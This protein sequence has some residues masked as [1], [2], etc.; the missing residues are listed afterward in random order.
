[1]QFQTWLEAL[2]LRVRKNPQRSSAAR[3]KASRQRP[4][5]VLEERTLLS[6]SSLMI[7]GELSIL[8]DDADSIV[9]RTNPVDGVS[10]QVIENGFQS[11]TLGNVMVANVTSINISGGSG[12]NTID[13]SGVTAAEFTGLTSVSV[14]GGDGDDTI[15]GTVDFNDTILAGDGNDTVTVGA[16][17]TSVDGGDGNDTITAG[18]GDD[19]IEGG[20]GH[21]LIM[22]GPG[23]DSVRAGD[24]NDT[25]SGED[26]DDTIDA[27]DGDDL[28]NGNAGMDLITGGF[29]DDMLMGDSDDDTIFGG[30]GADIIGGGDG[31]DSLVGNSQNDTIS[32]EAGDDSISAGSGNDLATGGDGDDFINGQAG[33]DT[34]DGENGNDRAL[35]GG[36]DDQI[37]GGEGDDTL[38]G[39]SGSDTLLGDNGIDYLN[40]GDGSDRLE[41]DSIRV[42][43]NSNQPVSRLFALAIDGNNQF[44]ELDPQSGAEL[45]RFNAP[46][47]FSGQQDGLAFDGTSLFYL[48]GSGTD[49]LYQI[50]PATQTVRHAAPITVGSGEYD[51]LAVIGG[52]VYIMDLNAIDIHVFD[53]VTSSIVNTLNINMVNPT[54]SVLVGGLAGAANPDRLIATETGGNRVVEIDPLTGLITNSFTPGTVGAGQ[55]YGAAVVN[56]E[57]YLG[58]GQQNSYDVFSRQGIFLRSVTLPYNVS[59]LGGDDVGTTPIIPGQTPQNRFNID[60]RFTGQFTPS[61]QA[62]FNAAAA[63][64]EEII[65][66]DVPDVFVPGIGQVDDIVIEAR[67]TAIDGPNGVLGQTAIIAQ[68]VVSNLPSAAFIAFDTFDIAALESSGQLSD[69]VLHEIGHALGFGTIWT[70]LGL[71]SGATGPDPQFL[72]PLSIQEYNLRFGTNAMGVPVE[73]MGGTG[74]ADSHWRESALTTELMTGFLDPGVANPITRL[75]VAQFADLG[76]QVDFAAADSVNLTTSVSSSNLVGERQ[77]INGILTGQFTSLGAAGASQGDQGTYI[78]NT[79]GATTIVQGKTQVLDYTPMMV[80]PGLDPTKAE[81]LSGANLTSA[82]SVTS[83]VKTQSGTASL[84]VP[85]MEPNDGLTSALNID[86]LGFSLDFDSNINDTL[87]INTSTVLPHL[88]IQGTGDGSFDFYSFTI[89]N[90]GD[91]AIF[92]IDFGTSVSNTGV[93]NGDPFDSQLFLFDA[94]GNSLAS[95][96]AGDDGSLDPGSFSS[97]DSFIEFTF[98]TPGTYVIGVSRSGSIAIPGG[99]SGPGVPTGS[100]YTLQVSIQNHLTSGTMTPTTTP[101]RTFGDTLIGGGGNGAGQGD[102]FFGSPGDDLIIGSNENDTIFAGDGMDSIYAGSGDDEINGEGGNDLIRGNGGTDT[103][104]GGAGDDA[105]SWTINDGSDSIIASDG[106]DTIDINGTSANDTFNISGVGTVLKVSA[107][108]ASPTIDPVLSIES[109]TMIV[110]VN[111]LAGNDTFNFASLDLVTDILLNVNGGAGQDMI[112]T[113]GVDL[114]GIRVAFDAGDGNDTILGGAGSETIVG[115][116]GNDVIDGGGGDDSIDGGAGDDVLVGGGGNDTIRGGL[117][118]DRIDGGDGNDSLDGGFNND[119]INGQAG[120]DSIDGGQANDLITGGDGNDTLLGSDGDDT[121]QGMAGRDFLV[122]GSEN[123]SLS[124]GTEDDTLRGGDGDDM[125]FGDDGNDVVNGGDGQDSIFGGDGDDTI[126]GGDGNDFVQ[127]QLGEDILL[128]GD[129]DDTIGGG[130]GRDV[131]LGGD[132]DDTV[133]GN[134]GT[135]TLA[136]NQGTDNVADPTG[137]DEINEQFQLD[138]AIL[139]LLETLAPTV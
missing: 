37:S 25:V 56:G 42:N 92:D 133:N 68:R 135:D 18:D 124:G 91:S 70:E 10:L 34:L 95:Q 46:E 17:A 38:L 104:D 87:G 65:V 132:G 112:N 96:T 44:V 113:N 60:I 69:T 49:T 73:N 76:Y 36:G 115:G 23:N 114:S 107:D 50:D 22:A 72:G 9:V 39:Q 12:A 83:N 81:T 109:G 2:R 77:R 47:P 7:N 117:G 28:I 5:E 118:L 16:G 75:T 127:G 11:T 84:V 86:N 79:F 21:D 58:S 43:P 53:P 45:F 4:A 32:G 126:T 67:S 89:A 52:L 131:L 100:D 119:T 20:D 82:F 108:V 93:L 125:I 29:G 61:Q 71:L 74:T 1:M 66:G 103:I 88:S 33:D 121:L 97:M 51:G 120:D 138:A 64:W 122:G 30:A 139:I 40:G 136:G 78:S 94:T 123:D 130:G 106:L 129:G 59:G 134:S 101:T 26:G 48:N 41:A 55:Y 62:V 3:R 105:I 13:L 111:G 57:I 80:I 24:G 35:G 128:G 14:T 31:N 137:A 54:V 102:L 116:D 98:A 27:G 63:R 90:A 110:N 99:I 8:S 85:E 6:V 19:T 15:T